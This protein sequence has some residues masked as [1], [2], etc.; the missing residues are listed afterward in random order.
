M[1]PATIIQGERVAKRGRLAIGCSAT[2]VDPATQ[3]ILLIRR[4]DTGRWAVPGGYMEPG[5]S[6]IEACVREVWEETGIQIRVKRLAAV[7]TNPH[8][9]AEYP[10]G[11]CVQ[12]VFLHFAAESIGGDLC[13]SEESPE[14]GYFSY[15]EIVGLDMNGLSRQRIDD[16]LAAQKAAVIRDTYTVT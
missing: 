1:I 12:V 8:L 4:A 16:A 5:E 11:N 13:T 14:V 10:D 2:V 3:K 15:A 9:V 7:Y 6:V